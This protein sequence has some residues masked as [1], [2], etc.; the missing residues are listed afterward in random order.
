MALVIPNVSEVTLLN[1]ML[2]VATPTNTIL[3]LYSN[4]L[5]PSSTT[6]VGDVT[7]VTSGG[8]AAITL[9][10]L[11]WTVATSGGGITTASYAEQTFNIT[12][13]ATVYGYY[14]TNVAGDL[15]WLERFTAA[16]FQL[17]GSGG[18]VLIT[19]Q[20]SLNSCA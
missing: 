10:S 9:T 6:V 7:E 17:P 8:Y 11:S 1:N 19:S 12:T 14:I 2:N 5:T 18:Q 16:P 4:N 3:H 13:S 20:V 15:L